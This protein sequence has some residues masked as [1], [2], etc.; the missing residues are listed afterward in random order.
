MTKF[1]L[2]NCHSWRE[3]S[4]DADETETLR[5][6]LDQA[7]GQS[8]ELVSEETIRV[9]ELKRGLSKCYHH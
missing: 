9:N 5:F 8:K 6:I 1:V 4:Q 2:M 3:Q 7:D